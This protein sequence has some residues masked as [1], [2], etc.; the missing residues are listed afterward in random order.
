MAGYL[1]KIVIEDT[2]PPVWRRCLIPDKI[3]F[4]ELHEII[5]VLF[6]WE[7]THLHGFEIP[8]DRIT[9]GGDDSWG[10]N[11]NEWETVVDPF[12]R[13]YKWIRYTY[14]FGDDWRH[15]INIEKI[16][17][18]YAERSAVL[19]KFKGDNFEED[20]G[21]VWSS[22]NSDRKAFN[23]GA[24]EEKLKLIELSRHE[25]LE[26]PI[27]LKESM[28]S[29]KK[30]IQ[31]FRKLEPEV[32]QKTLAQ[33]A[34]VFYGKESTIAQKI[35]EWRAFEE[36]GI[37]ESLQFVLPTKSQKELLMDLGEKEATDYYKYL[38]IP[39]SGVMSRE[40]QVNAISEVLR[41]H[42][43][44]LLYIFDEN[45]YQELTEW[46]KYTAHSSLQ[47]TR[48]K[49]MLIKALGLGLADFCRK[50][51]CCEICLASDIDQ[52]IGVLDAKT[53][54][55]TY[56]A[57]TEFDRR[58]GKLL[59]VYGLMEL[60][61]LYEIYKDLYERNLDKED[62]F[63]YIYWHARFN[64]M[65]NT[66][67][68][69]NGTCY[70]AMKELDA[71]G[72]I[73]KMAVYAEDLPYA[74]YSKR[75]ID[76]KGEDLAN[77]SEWMDI[78]FTTLHYQLKMDIY[79]AQSCMYEI[80]S[81][82]MSGESLNQIIESVEVHNGKSW[83]LGTAAEVWTVITGLMLELEL[84]M[85]KG[86]YR[87]GYAR[88][89]N[90]SAWSVGMVTG[91]ESILTNRNCYMYQFPA[92]V[93]E[94]MYEAANMGSGDAIKQ[95]LDYKEKKHICSEEYLYLLADACITF[96]YTKEA[97][98]LILQLRS[99]SAVGKKAAKHLDERQ[100]ER[101][102]VMDDDED[103]LEPGGWNW[104][105]QETVQQPYVRESPKIGRNDPC[106]CGS[107]KKYK[108]CCGKDH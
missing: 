67:Y 64:D 38:R 108:K 86:R 88:E 3:T 2:H 97:N 41:K 62:F 6:A 43:E 84:P 28:E 73:E 104:M 103:G 63:R 37:W 58:M 81:A 100:Q 40:K 29:L 53:K 60:E 18:D 35:N 106:P 32:Q 65:V 46:M 36:E 44:Y 76:F 19:M 85:L 17:M 105:E 95:L 91:Q 13:N 61:S 16:D 39:R 70:V 26:E 14:D 71:Q 55:S 101:F 12:F 56:K 83:S 52:V 1:C 82:I 79:E 90:C 42:P 96:G 8:S 66:V 102:D 50:E 45:E 77:R 75:E 89:Q 25:E 5:Q 57:L 47:K 34:D 30:L 21:G 54:K 98:K 59:Q 78:L 23:R 94:W 49:G 87:L 74:R 4:G 31:N 68:Q 11:Y 99:S 69:L 27:S 9:I 92:E 15:R 93:Q 48:R 20:S 80:V 107:G 51:S 7:N 24:V 22:A 72:I 10:N 33:A